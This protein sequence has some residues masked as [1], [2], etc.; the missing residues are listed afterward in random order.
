[1]LRI[2]SKSSIENHLKQLGYVTKLDIWVPH[3]L[4]EI[5][6]TKRINICDSLLKCEEIGLFLKCVLTGDEKWIIY[7]NVEQKSSWRKRDETAQSTSKADIHQ[8]KVMLSTWWDFKGGV[9]FQRLPRNHMINSMCTVVNWV[10]EVMPSNRS[11]QNGGVAE[12][13]SCL[14]AIPDPIQTGHASIVVGAGMGFVPAPVVFTRP[15]KTPWMVKYLP[16]MKISNCSWHSVLP[17]QK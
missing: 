9:Y 4:K 13:W 7:N 1:M 8:R 10:N 2:L 15:C 11:I 6:F 14:L 16:F 12:A 3:E 17:K 5:H